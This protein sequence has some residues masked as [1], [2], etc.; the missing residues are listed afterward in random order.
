MSAGQVTG[1]I[2]TLIVCRYGQAW[3]GKVNLKMLAATERCRTILTASR[4]GRHSEHGCGSMWASGSS[5]LVKDLLGKEP[6]TTIRTGK[7]F[8]FC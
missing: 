1:K 4:P 6:Q 3:E 8:M 7:F 2:S 5:P